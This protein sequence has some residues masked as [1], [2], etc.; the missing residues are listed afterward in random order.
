MSDTK[1][2]KL[3][4]DN[5][6]EKNAQSLAELLADPQTP[7]SVRIQIIN[8]IHGESGD[9]SFFETMYN[10]ML[11]YGECPCCGHKN[12]WGIPE[13]TL[14]QMGFVSSQRDH[15]VLPHTTEKDCPSYAEACIKKKLTT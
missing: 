12:H 4:L 2:N 3:S 13:D 5:F 10:E 11:T 14:V 6:D 15:R 1:S 7:E 9:Q 8:E